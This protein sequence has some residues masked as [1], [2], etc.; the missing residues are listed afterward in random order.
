MNHALKCIALML[1]I[2]VLNGCYVS[3]PLDHD[4]KI[5]INKDFPVQIKNEGK[6]NFSSKHS[7]DEYRQ[8]YLTEMTKELQINHIVIDDAAPQFIA[9]ISLL[10]I[11]ESTKMDTVKD[12]KSKDNGMIRELTMAGLKTNGTIA[13]AGETTNHN[14]QAEK[15]KDESLTNNQSFDQFVNGQNKDHSSY[16][17]KAFDDTEFVKQAGVCGRRAAVRITNEIQRLLK[18]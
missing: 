11:T 13:K 4:V 9:K 14:W 3:K 8:S 1:A 18:K 7:E 17:E 10:E 2:T 16:R 12:E 5:S 15:A 6:S